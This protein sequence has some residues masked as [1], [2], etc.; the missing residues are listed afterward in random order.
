MKSLILGIVLASVS[1]SFAQTDGEAS[2]QLKNRLKA[3]QMMKAE[4]ASM[5]ISDNS[6]PKQVK[7]LSRKEAKSS[8]VSGILRVKNGTPF[9]DVENGRVHRKLVPTNFSKDMLRDFEGKTIQF[10]YTISDHPLPKQGEFSMVVNLHEV[11]IV[12]KR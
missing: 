11:A 8:L 12:K 9:I 5:H 10:R 7:T 4:P 3:K 6:E 2:H 1:F